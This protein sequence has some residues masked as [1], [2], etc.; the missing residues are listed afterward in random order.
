MP[1]GL[2]IPSNNSHGRV[3]ELIATP[4]F[5]WIAIFRL[6]RLIKKDVQVQDNLYMHILANIGPIAS[7]LAEK[8]DLSVF[9][10]FKNRFSVFFGF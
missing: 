10:F 8:T 4:P 7:M 3:S 2:S 9:R 5:K 1:I 6:I